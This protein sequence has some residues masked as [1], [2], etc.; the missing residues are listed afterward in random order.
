MMYIFEYIWLDGINNCRSKTKVYDLQFYHNKKSLSL[1]DIPEWNYDGSSTWQATTENSEVILKPVRIYK[2]PFRGTDNAFLVLCENYNID[3]TPHKD[4]M[5]H[6]ANEIFNKAL[7]EEPMFGLEQEFFICKKMK[8]RVQSN[9]KPHLMRNKPL[10]LS[11]LPNTYIDLIQ[12]NIKVPK[13]KHYC[14]VGGEVILER[15]LM[16]VALDKLLYCGISVTGLN[17][18]VAPSQWEFQVCAVGIKASDDLIMLR[19]ICNR[20][21]ELEGMFME[22]HPKIDFIKNQNENGSGCHINFSTKKMR[23]KGGFSHIEKAINNLS[24]H[25]ELHIKHY[26]KDNE[27]RLT[28]KHETSDIKTFSVGV[29]SRNTS[30]RI[31]SDTKKNNM[32]Y[33]EDRRPSSNLDPYISTSLL[34]ATSIG[35]EQTYFV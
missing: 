17:A 27:L 5:R 35:L 6:Y 30:I 9:Y 8:K 20:V 21:F 22:L 31:P 23:E 1:K 16:D 33:F 24:K 18:E 25:H 2:D 13:G 11:Y 19:Y 32:G 14:G 29:G 3:G 4:N 34:F 12:D 15:H 10:D 26:G 28:G 7:K